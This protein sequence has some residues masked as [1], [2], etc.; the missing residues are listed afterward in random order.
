M[1]CWETIYHLWIQRNN[2]IYVD[3]VKTHEQILK[4]IEI[5]NTYIYIYIY[6]KGE[7]GREAV[8]WTTPS[9]AQFSVQIGLF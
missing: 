3:E 6:I 8:K 4:S 7:E 2:R 5:I 1:L 9:L